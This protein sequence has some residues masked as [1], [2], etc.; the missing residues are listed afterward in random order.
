M[1]VV[2]R[3]KLAGF[4]K[5]SGGRDNLQVV[6]SFKIAWADIDDLYL[7]LFPAAVG[8]FPSPP[9][10]YGT[11]TVI[12]ADSMEAEPFIGEDDVPNCASDL[13]TYTY[14]RVTV[15]YKT[16]PY[17]QEKASDDAPAGQLITRNWVVSGEFLTLP[18][19]GLRWND[20]PD[21]N[22]VPPDVVCGITCPMVDI[23]VTLHRVTAAYF[24]TLLQD[25]YDNIGKVNTVAFESAN[26][27]TL[28]LLGADFTQTVSSDGTFTYEC[29]IKFQYKNR[30]SDNP[31]ADDEIFGWNIF[32]DPMRGEWRHLERANGDPI[33]DGFDFADLY[34]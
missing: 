17:E 8:G 33:Y 10:N 30:A 21:N 2:S 26:A 13:Q 7:E 25:I 5:W 1:P 34:N 14:A 32:Y 3:E 11:S 15:T 16:I 18:T 31:G 20:D 23:T 6:D 19:A 29:A 9:E 22:V 27:Y 28:L 12:F 4:P 24:A